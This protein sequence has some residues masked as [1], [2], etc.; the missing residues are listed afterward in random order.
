LSYDIM[1]YR[2]SG[3]ADLLAQARARR[4]GPE[5]QTP[6]VEKD[7]ERAK[8]V[9]DLLAL[10]PSLYSRPS[11]KGPS[12]GLGIYTTDLECPVPLIEIDIDDAIV[13][14]PYSA[15]FERI[16]PELTRVIKVFERHGYTAY[17]P[18]IDAILTSSSSFLESA[19]SFA[20]T[21]HDAVRHMQARGETVIGRTGQLTGAPSQKKRSLT[22]L[23]LVV[24][25]LAAIG[26]VV[27]RQQYASGLPPY[28]TKELRDLQERLKSPG[29]LFPE[30]LPHPERR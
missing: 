29:T 18:Q 5:E 25:V 7:R 24:F 9:A 30:S 26:V 22:L 4:E 27:T 2:L 15:D 17:D 13:T 3:T 6:S 20:T 14:F 10:D 28:A 16:R 11:H 19:S 23:G 8:L 1:L 12:F 21:G